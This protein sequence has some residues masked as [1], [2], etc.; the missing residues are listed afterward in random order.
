MGA[1]SNPAAR[2]VRAMESFTVRMADSVAVI[3]EGFA[4]DLATNLGADLGTIRTL[5]NWTHVSEPDPLSSKAFRASRGWADDEI[6]ILHAGNMGTK[7]GLENVI[8]A[9]RIAGRQDAAV[10]FVLMG[11]GHRRSHLQSLGANVPC[12]EFVD[13]VPDA[14][15]P[16]ALGAA[17]VLLVNELPGVAQMAMPSKLTSYFVAGKPVLAA[18]DANGFT[19]REIA[20]SRA[21][22]RIAAGDPDALVREALRIGSDHDLARSLGEAGRSYCRS[23]LSAASALDR[24][25]DWISNLAGRH[26][27]DVL[28]EQGGRR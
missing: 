7:Q 16:A 2:L 5:R 24:Y 14:D 1:Q 22:V 10:R 20:L 9:A 3:H 28:Q 27:E 15:F 21:G 19:A 4:D 18:T 8:A 6:V 26:T 25:E 17:D 12:L 11:D 23:A 13:P